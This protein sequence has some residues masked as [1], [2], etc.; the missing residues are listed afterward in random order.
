MVSLTSVVV[1]SN[2][3]GNLRVIAN[4]AITANGVDSYYANN[5]GGFGGVILDN[6]DAK[7]VSAVSASNLSSTNNA[8]VGLQ[9]DSRGR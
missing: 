4:G 2:Y 7:A 6:S 8:I 3:Y 1:R 5:S 9:V